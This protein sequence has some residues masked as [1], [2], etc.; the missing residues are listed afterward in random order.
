MIEPYYQKGSIVI[1]N[2]DC[3]EV[4]KQFKDKTFNLILTD[5]PKRHKQAMGR[6]GGVTKHIN[7]TP[8]K[9][10]NQI[11]P[12]EYFNEMFRVSE[13]QIIFGGNYFVEYLRNSSCWL[14]W[15]KDNGKT[16]FADC[17]LC[18]T[19]FKGAIRKFKW[20][21]NGMLQEDMKH[22]EKR[23]HPTQKP[24]GLLLQIL[25][26]YPAKTILDP[27]MGSGS[28]LIAARKLGIDAIGIEMNKEY[29]DIAVKRLEKEGK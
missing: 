4:M 23:Y 25:E 15:D 20:R 18:W 28:T 14:V 7:Y 5:P 13:D 17:E 3:L 26:R 10:D 16:S 12:R 8:F 19:S 29:C 24:V 9:W 11:P 22:K 1:Y 21:W 27:F 2:N 6:G